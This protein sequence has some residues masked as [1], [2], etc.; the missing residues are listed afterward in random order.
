MKYLAPANFAQWMTNN[1]HV[2]NK[3][4]HTYRYHS[5]SDSHS[6]ALCLLVVD[7]LVAACPVLAK[8]ASEGK[9]V[10]GINL[11]YEWPE[12][13]KVKTI[14]LAIGVSSESVVELMPGSRIAKGKIKRVLFSCEA[15]TCMTEHGKSQPRI[16]DE[17]GSSHAIVHAGDNEAIAAGITVVNIADRFASPL[18]Q[19][20]GEPLHFTNHKQPDAAAGMIYHLRGLPIRAETT[21]ADAGFDAY[22]TLVINCDN[23]EPASLWTT[24]P[25][26]QPGE[27]DHY[28][29]FVDRIAKAYTERFSSL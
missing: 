8:H 12:S 6:K 24:P 26:P 20:K 10:Y 17:L 4:E 23:Q 5:R 7:D 22:T 18:R 29:T 9:V 25:A 27:R 19:E 16:F 2:D 15:K 21:S 13:K 14:D 28:D 1:K 3:Y 11:V